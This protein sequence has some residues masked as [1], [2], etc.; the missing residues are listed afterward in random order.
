MLRN[1]PLVLGLLAALMLPSE[2]FA[3]H[4]GGHGHGGH[5]HGGHAR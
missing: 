3:K 5:G 2:T 1:I 4:G